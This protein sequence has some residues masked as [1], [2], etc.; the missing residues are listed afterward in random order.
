M[1]RSNS[2]SSHI[3]FLHLSKIKPNASL[4]LDK[5]INPDLPDRVCLNIAGASGSIQ[6]KDI[7]NSCEMTIRDN[8]FLWG[9][10]AD[11]HNDCER[12]FLIKLNLY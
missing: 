9:I 10:T 2:F 1:V 11:Y 4:A 8:G 3:E 6:K 7:K 5:S 12:Y